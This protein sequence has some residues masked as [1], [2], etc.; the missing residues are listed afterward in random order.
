[1][2]RGGP[3]IVD[4]HGH[5]QRNY[6]GIRSTISDEFREARYPHLGAGTHCTCKGDFRG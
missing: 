3:F 6:I 4:A 5:I 1:M 2:R